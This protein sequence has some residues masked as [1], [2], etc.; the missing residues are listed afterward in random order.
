MN[1]FS[2]SKDNFNRSKCQLS[3]E[4]QN[5]LKNE[6]YGDFEQCGHSPKCIV[7]KIMTIDRTLSQKDLDEFRKTLLPVVYVKGERKKECNLN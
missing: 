2:I 5:C 6:D 4:F 7:S 3:I 1:L